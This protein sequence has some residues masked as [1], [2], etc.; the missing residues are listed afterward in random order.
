MPYAI[1]YVSTAKDLDE[2]EIT[3]LLNSS[4]ANNKALNISGLLIYNEGNFFQYME[5]EKEDILDLYENKILKDKR[6]DSIFLLMKKEIDALYFE[7]YETGFTPVLMDDNAA[8]LR[9]Y[10][11][12][13]KYLDSDEI[14]AV[15]KTIDAFLGKSSNK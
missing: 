11:K 9:Q 10:L 14:N 15:T 3:E 5:G 4:S 1:T 13:L 2:S 7:G 6:H 8:G 12:L